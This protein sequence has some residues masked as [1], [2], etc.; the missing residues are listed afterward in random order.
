MT[1]ERGGLKHLG[2]NRDDVRQHNLSTLLR[3]IHQAGKVSRSTLT[4]NTGL[5]RSTIS[6]LVAELQDLG[7]VS[8]AE[9]PA[10]GIG[11]PSLQVSASDNIVAFSVSV[12]VDA[13][14]VGVVSLSG[15]II[16]RR[17]QATKQP[18]AKRAAQI[19]AK[20]ISEIRA[21]LQ[22]SIKIVGVG[23]AVPGQIRFSDGVVRYAP[24]LGWV[25]VPFAS[26]VSQLTGLPVFV[27]NDASVGCAAERLYGN[28]RGYS[29]VVYLFAG[30]GGIG[31]AVV[32]GD[33]KLRGAAGYAGELGHIRI[34]S[35]AVN[36]Y[37]GLEGTLEGLVRREDLVTALELKSV[38]DDLLLQEMGSAKSARA[39]KLIGSQIDHLA[40]ALG[41]CVNIFNPQIVILGGFLAGLLGHDQQRLIQGMQTNSLSAAVERVVVREGALGSNLLLIGCAELAFSDLIER[42]STTVLYSARPGTVFNS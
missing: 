18:T 6:D 28:A 25:E 12:D 17:R 35:K 16:E 7:L 13:V 9:A 39:L 37:S 1:A 40:Q 22:S 19:A 27:D 8:E 21:S 20:V 30:S 42:P 2:Q 34:S 38:N 3:L 32:V 26:M 5:N 33:V 31:G 24:H 11:R 36:D 41:S 29:D 23:V 10:E 4:S 15:Q 14:T